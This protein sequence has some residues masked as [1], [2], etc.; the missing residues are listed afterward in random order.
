MKKTILLAAGIT[1]LFFA[2]QPVNAQADIGIRVGGIHVNVGDRPN[3]VIETRPTFVY[4]PE[5]GF[6]V[7]VGSPYDFAYFDGSYYISR[8]GYWYSSSYYG[9]PWA[10]VSFDRLPHALRAHRWEEI[11]RFRDR[12]YRRHDHNY[13][14]NRDRHDE[15]DRRDG[16]DQRHEENRDQRNDHNR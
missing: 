11:R 3:F 12:E 4:V 8:D 9:G 16:R 1:I 7:A 14:E 6:S 5:L 13:W 2:H 15:H 10:V